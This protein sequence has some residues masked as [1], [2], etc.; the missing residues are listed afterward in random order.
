M[1]TYLW[2]HY[3]YQSTK[4]LDYVILARF[5]PTKVGY[6]MSLFYDNVENIIFMCLVLVPK[7]GGEGHVSG[8]CCLNC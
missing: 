7:K 6:I 1:P 8:F 2:T 4:F 5:T 3:N